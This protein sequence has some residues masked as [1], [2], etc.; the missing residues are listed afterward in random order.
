MYRNKEDVVAYHKNLWIT[1]NKS[2][3]PHLQR[4]YGITVDDYNIMF[5]FQEGKCL[6]CNKHQS[7]LKSA[8]HV[9]HDHETGKIRG[10][11]CK[12]CNT[13]IGLMKDSIYNL[14]NMINYLSK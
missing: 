7:E 9:D 13:A 10:L 6:G 2:K 14:N 1:K 11:L 4:T 8:L 5:A 3:K 12:K